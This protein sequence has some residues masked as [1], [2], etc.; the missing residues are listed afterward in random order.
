MGLFD[1]LFGKKENAKPKN[2]LCTITKG[3]TKIIANYQD[4]ILDGKCIVFGVNS[5]PYDDPGEYLFRE[6]FYIKG[7]LHGEKKEYWKKD[8]IKSIENYDNGLKHG[9]CELYH[10]SSRYETMKSMFGQV[11]EGT[12]INL[13]SEKGIYKQDKK[14]GLWIK[15]RDIEGMTESQ[16]IESETEF[17]NGMKNGFHKTYDV[18]HKNNY[19][20]YLSSECFFIDDKLEGEYLEF[21]RTSKVKRR[22][23]YKSG[24]KI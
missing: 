24:E 20:I 3:N 9:C 19:K 13:L 18:D 8:V 7:R 17:K 6:C 2:G 4:D 16:V 5:N 15:Y 10:T 1:F 14:E 11:E 22:I 21:H 12:P 23:T